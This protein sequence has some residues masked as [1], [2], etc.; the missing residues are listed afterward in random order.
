MAGGAAPPAPEAPPLRW[1]LVE[2]HRPDDVLQCQW[3]K[4]PPRPSRPVQHD[5]CTLFD[6]ADASLRPRIRVVVDAGG[7]EPAGAVG[8]RRVRARI[9]NS[10][11]EF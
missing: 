11:V 2:A 3:P 8:G 10:D 7:D 9:Q 1:Q 4:L 5:A 6:E